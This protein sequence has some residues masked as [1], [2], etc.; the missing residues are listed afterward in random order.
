MKTTDS[1]CFGTSLVSCAMALDAWQQTNCRECTKARWYN[2]KTGRMPKY[3]CA[4]QEQIERQANEGGAVNVRSYDAVHEQPVCLFINKQQ[5]EPQEH[6]RPVIDAHEFAKGECIEIPVEQ[7]QQAEPVQETA[8]EIDDDA[9]AQ[10]IIDSLRDDLMAASANDKM[11]ETEIQARAR[12][13]A[14]RFAEKTGMADNPEIREQVLQKIREKIGN[15]PRRLQETLFKQ[16]IKNDVRELEQAFTWDEH[17][18]ISYVPLV[19]QVVAWN[20]AF[21]ARQIAVDNRIPQTIKLSR[22]IKQ[23]HKQW[24]DYIERDL[25]KQHIQQIEQAANEWEQDTGN[26]QMILWLQV[27]QAYLTQRPNAGYRDIRVY[28]SCALLLAEFVV[29]YQK[30]IDVMVSERLQRPLEPINWPYL[31]GMVELMRGFIQDETIEHTPNIDMCMRIL[32][33]RVGRIKWIEQNEPG[34]N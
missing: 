10:A 15:D 2:E 30:K 16:Q 7:E 19:L 18:K 24:Y 5:A 33:N 11:T 20:Y 4:I 14:K 27:Q 28:A 25:S 6:E 29:D 13:A 1:W 23:I 8:P 31:N 12:M 26:D 9:L 32:A 22:A 3:H 34:N 21:K 17:M